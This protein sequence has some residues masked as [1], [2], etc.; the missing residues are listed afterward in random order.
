MKLS[1][2]QAAQLVHCYTPVSRQIIKLSLGMKELIVVFQSLV[3]SDVK[4]HGFFFILNRGKRRS[5]NSHA[6]KPNLLQ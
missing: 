6:S 2:G 4:S 1:L 5:N 3:G